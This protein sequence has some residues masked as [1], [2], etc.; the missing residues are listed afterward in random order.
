[1]SAHPAGAVLV[2]AVQ[3][4]QARRTLAAFPNIQFKRAD[5]TG[6]LAAYV[7][8][9]V[10]DTLEIPASPPLILDGYGLII[11]C[12]ILSQLPLPFA[13]S[14]PLTPQDATITHAIIKAHL[15]MLKATPVPILLVSDYERCETVIPEAHKTTGAE[16][17]NTAIHPTIP[18]DLLPPNPLRTWRWQ[19]A[20]A[21]EVAARTDISLRV[22]AWQLPQP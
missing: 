1:L 5:I 8:Q 7:R 14:P 19:I 13:N 6:L 21:G 22:A 9:K 4:R 17:N 16:R 18:T 2:D 15:D 10:G 20:P 12:N 11:S 3:T